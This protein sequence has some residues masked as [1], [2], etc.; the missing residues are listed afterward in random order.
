MVLKDDVFYGR[1]IMKIPRPVLLSAETAALPADMRRELARV[2]FEDKILAKKFNITSEDAI[3][4][5]S[6]AYPLIHENR[7]SASIF[8]EWMDAVKDVHLPV[9]QFTERQ[10][11]VLNG[12][13]VESA[14]EEMLKNVNIIVDSSRNFSFFRYAEVSRGEAE[15]ALAVIM[16]HARVVHPHQDAREATDP[17]MYLVPLVE[18][19]DVQFHQDP[20][21]G[22]S[23]QEEITF[24]GK[25]EEEMVLQIARRD[26]PKGDEVFF[27]PGRFSNSDMAVRFGHAFARNNV[28][29]GR[30]VTQPPNWEM[31]KE[32]NIRKEYAKYNCSNL[33]AFELRLSTLGTP[34][35]IWTRCFR[36]SWFL[37]NGWYSPALT[38]R[39][40]D[41]DNWP[42]PKRYTKDDW[43]AWTQADRELNKNVLEYCQFMRT[44][45]KDTIDVATAKEFRKSSDP[46]DRLVWHL[47]GEES[48][49]FKECA[50]QAKKIDAD[51]SR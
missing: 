23:F 49:T 22:I 24:E 16:R 2:L 35:R 41:L 43:L 40:R 14:R 20:G 27:W 25:R 30:N 8:R 7:D 21:V 15:W 44:R 4:L 36:V 42:P 46:M 18:L 34:S 11:R 47:R 26:M 45:L 51:V 29:I 13:T 32:S 5:L 38:K 37:A 19:L 39:I 3:H 17:R 12:T 6:L 50:I 48:K 31:H 10:L 9:L 28:G 1:A 33:E